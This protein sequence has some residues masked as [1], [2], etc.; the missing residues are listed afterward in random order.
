MEMNTNNVNKIFKILGVKPNE[1]F[2]IKGNNNTLPWLYKIDK[3]LTV[4]SFYEDNKQW[5]WKPLYESAILQSLLNGTYTIVKF[6]KMTKE[7]KIAIEY[8]KACGCK[9]MAKDDNYRVFAYKEKPIKGNEIW[10]IKSRNPIIIPIEIPIS[11]ISFD[12]EE[13]YCLE[14]DLS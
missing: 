10:H 8:A 1:R 13:P 3:K 2:R 4:L 5:K 6:T 7:E 9:W 12:D 11:F 14:N